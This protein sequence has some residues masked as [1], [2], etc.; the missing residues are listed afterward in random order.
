MAAVTAIILILAGCN[1][2]PEI[3]EAML[4]GKWQGVESW[5]QG[6]PKTPRTG[7]FSN[8]N[9]DGTMTEGDGNQLYVTARWKLQTGPINYLILQANNTT[10]TYTV[11][12]LTETEAVL[13]LDS[14]YIKIKR[15]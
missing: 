7:S 3:T 1:K 15:L 4:Y 5:E 12:S 14:V 11:V 8:Y 6:G 2:T 10:I 9:L 13:K